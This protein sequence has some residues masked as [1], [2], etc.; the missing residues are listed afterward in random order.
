MGHN[1]KAF[2]KIYIANFKEYW[3][4]RDCYLFSRELFFQAKKWKNRMEGTGWLFNKFKKAKKKGRKSLQIS[5][6]KNRSQ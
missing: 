5:P 1:R 3:R 4:V 2:E 6:K